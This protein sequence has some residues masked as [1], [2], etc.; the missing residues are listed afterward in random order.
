MGRDCSAKKTVAKASPKISGLVF[1]ELIKR[2]YSLDGNT[3]VW[4]IAD[5][6]LWYLTPEQAQAYLDAEGSKSFQKLASSVE[7]NLIE[8]NL[9][10]IKREVGDG[11]I[12]LVDLG[13]GDGNKAAHLIRKLKT[14]NKIRYCPIDIS[15]YMVRKA[16]DNVSKMREVDEIVESR[17]N[18]SDFENLENVTN[19]LEEGEFKKSLFILLGYTL[20]NFE[21]NDFLYQIRTSMKKGDVLLVVTGIESNHWEKWTKNK[22]TTDKLNSFFIY[23]PLLLGV[24][25][26]DLEFGARLRNDRVEYY[27]TIVND[28][29][30][31]F[32]GKKVCFKKGDQIIVAVSYKHKKDD[33]LTYLNIHF[34]NVFVRIS[35]DGATAFALCKK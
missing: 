2:G 31:E 1:K 19:L 7:F 9:E 20:G 5:S 28:R 12:N 11:S 32:Q 24:N 8:E 33:F 13:C 34:D 23:T 30:I 27:Y 16:I 22:E 3:R 26:E 21:V 25:R 10:E 4:N 6:K 15:A 18:I 29:L 35:K 17:W 14:H